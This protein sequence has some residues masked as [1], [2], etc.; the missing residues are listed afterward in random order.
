MKRL[1]LSELRAIWVGE[2][3]VAL[4]AADYKRIDASAEA[5]KRALS[6]GEAIYGVNTGF[7]KLA[8]TRIE[9][10]KLEQLQRNLVLSHCAGVG[11]DLPD[12]IVRLA[13]ALKVLTLAQGRS[14]VQ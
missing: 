12:R 9:P 14:G 11:P 10:D 5:V 3:A 6:S 7:G 13:L 1:T 8:T 2:G 4:A